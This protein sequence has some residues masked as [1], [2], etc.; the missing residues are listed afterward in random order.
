[1]TL[2]PEIDLG[3]QGISNLIYNARDKHMHTQYARCHIQK[4]E[5]ISES[6]SCYGS[7]KWYE[8]CTLVSTDIKESGRAVKN[9]VVRSP[10]LGH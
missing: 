1:M 7:N 4:K 8:K 10:M 3:S 9:S 5:K 2:W 6:I